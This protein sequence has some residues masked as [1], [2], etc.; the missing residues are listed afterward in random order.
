[1][2]EF[3]KHGFRCEVDTRS[4]KVGYKIR[5]AQLEKIP[6]M[7]IVGQKNWRVEVSVRKR[8]EGDKGSIGVTEFIDMLK[9]KWS[10]N[11]PFK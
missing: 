7:L 3:K 2:D 1:M 4:E 8:D 10:S 9:K 11:A 6:Y 5:E